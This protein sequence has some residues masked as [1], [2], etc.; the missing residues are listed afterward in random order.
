MPCVLVCVHVGVVSCVGGA[1]Q[2]RLT[3]HPRTDLPRQFDLLVHVESTAA[4]HP[5]DVLPQPPRRGWLFGCHGGGGGEDDWSE[6]PAGGEAG[7][8]ET[9]GDMPELWPSGV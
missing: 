9:H 5:L 2:C 3:T 8:G 6:A 4:V 1:K 7:M